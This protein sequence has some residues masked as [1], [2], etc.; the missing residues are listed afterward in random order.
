MQKALGATPRVDQRISTFECHCGNSR[1]QN[2]TFP[3]FHRITAH[4]LCAARSRLSLTLFSA[5]VC[6]GFALVLGVY[7]IQTVWKK[8]SEHTDDC[9]RSEEAAEERK[10]YP[11]EFSSTHRSVFYFFSRSSN[12]YF[13]GSLL[14]L[15][16]TQ[17]NEATKVFF[18]SNFDHSLSAIHFTFD[19]H[20]SQFS[21]D[22]RTCS[23][24]LVFFHI[25]FDDVSRAA[26]ER[27]SE[28]NDSGSRKLTGSPV[29]PLNWRNWKMNTHKNVVYRTRFNEFFFH[30]SYVW[31]VDDVLFGS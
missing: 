9:E 5:R 29:Q 12:R 18:L 30:S 21:L 20:M 10:I 24:K 16:G 27:E 7:N 15:A 1:I 3:F 17:I 28:N 8:Q 14:R 23:S 11:W 6:F 2:R 22:F 4:K 26:C 31:S 13:D 19:G 25:R